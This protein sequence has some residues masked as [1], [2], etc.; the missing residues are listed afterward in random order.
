MG[1][2]NVLEATRSCDSVRV[3]LIVTSDKCYD[4]RE[5]IWPYRE[6]EPLGG[7]DPYSS[8]KAAAELATTAYRRS[9]FD[10]KDDSVP[11]HCLGQGRQRY[12]GR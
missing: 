7:S 12:W 5:W 8:S 11:A 4:N 2:V 3:V 1:T 6:N 10:T 9:F